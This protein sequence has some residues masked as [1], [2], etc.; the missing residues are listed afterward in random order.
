MESP[1][2][3]RFPKRARVVA[4]RDYERAQSRGR[5]RRGDHLT[6]WLSTNARGV[7]RLGMAVS[8]KVGKSHDR[9]KLRRRLRELFRR[10]RIPLHP[11]YDH[12]V[13]AR[14]GA[15]EM[16]FDDLARELTQLLGRA[17]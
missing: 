3:E 11:G 9:Q 15:A 17:P 12:I 10:H 5:R 1:R 6:L 14:P 13:V 7:A 2:T 4:S 8:R 16:S